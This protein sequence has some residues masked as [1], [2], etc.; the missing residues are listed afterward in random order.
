MEFTTYS[1]LLTDLVIVSSIVWYMYN[2]YIKEGL[3]KNEIKSIREYI[4][5]RH[6]IQQTVNK[7]P[8]LVSTVD[9]LLNDMKKLD[10]NISRIEKILKEN[11]EMTEEDIVNRLTI[12]D[13][14]LDDLKKL[15]KGHTKRLFKL[16]SDVE[17]LNNDTNFTKSKSWCLLESQNNM[18]KS[19]I[20]E[21]HILD[22]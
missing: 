13:S 22:E 5:T 7:V 20:L 4:K 2:T 10:E 6:M 9:Y 11:K 15:T 12:S 1:I 18:S 16:Q 3:T 14:S 8:K 17:E 19:D 21:K